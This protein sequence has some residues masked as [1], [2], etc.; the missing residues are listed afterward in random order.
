MCGDGPLAI[1]DMEIYWLKG[2][3]FRL[4]G[5]AM[6]GPVPKTL[7]EQRCPADRDNTLI[8]RNDPLLVKTP[9]N[10]VLV[11]TG[12]GNKLTTKQKS[13][14]KVST[15]WNLPAE[16]N[17]IGLSR[18]EIT[19]VVLTHG[20]FDH[21]GGVAMLTDEGRLEL[22]CPNAR[23]F[24][25]RKEWEDVVAPHPR[26][27]SVY[28]E[29]DFSSLR[30]SHHLELIDGDVVIC[31]GISLRFSGGHTR[32]HQVVDM[33]S[34]DMVVVHLGDLYPTHFHVNPLWVMAYDNYPLEVIDRKI[35]YFSE[36]SAQNSWFTFYHDPVVRACRLDT[37]GKICETWPPPLVQAV[38]GG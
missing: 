21:A 31:P 18:E 5:G 27:K 11:D 36:Y 14:F 34:G 4:D 1:G 2:G 7:W 19:D 24:L 13:V 26:A 17:A 35:E 30:D 33:R 10:L 23:H 9:S 6:F 29:E 25:Q 20:D 15:P 16:L 32:G 12:L 38:T 37:S 8:F 3:N 28:L 22:T